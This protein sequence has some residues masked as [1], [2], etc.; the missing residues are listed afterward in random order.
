MTCHVLQANLSL[1]SSLLRFTENSL[2]NLPIRAIII[3]VKCIIMPNRQISLDIPR[4]CRRVLTCR[5]GRPICVQSRNTRHDRCW[6]G[7]TYP[8]H[9]SCNKIK[10]L[11]VYISHIMRKP[12]LVYLQ[13]KTQINFTV[14]MRLISIF[15]CSTQIV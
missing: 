9:I 8:S 5:S 13:T 1:Q 14:T 6:H 10:L 12:F 7:Y 4:Q 15:V 11:F 3:G 2:N